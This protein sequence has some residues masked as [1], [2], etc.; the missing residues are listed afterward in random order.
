MF[1]VPATPGGG[2][3][4]GSLPRFARRSWPFGHTADRHRSPGSV[5]RRVANGSGEVVEAQSRMR[6]DQVHHAT[7][8]VPEAVL[9]RDEARQ[10][11]E[12]VGVELFELL[13]RV[14]I[15]EVRTPSAQEPI[16]GLDHE[17]GR[18][19]DP[20]EWGEL[21]DPIPS[22]RHRG[23]RWPAGWEVS[24]PPT[25]P[26][27]EVVAKKVEAIGPRSAIDDPG[28]TWR[29]RQP[30]L[31]EPR[32][33]ELECGFGLPARPAHHDQI[34]RITDDLPVLAA[35]FLP[36]LIQTVQVD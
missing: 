10:P 20:G 27:P 2:P 18:A 22:R 30:Q 28:L 29:E 1:S 17:D 31:A 23:Q 15:A 4:S 34:V 19:L 16:D 32:L 11:L 14:A 35:V 26:H 13:G 5:R 24:S 25:G 21:A 3:P 7:P 9:A 12:E 36:C 8:P 6:L 33:Q